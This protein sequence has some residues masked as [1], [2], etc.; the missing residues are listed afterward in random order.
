MSVFQHAANC[1]RQ[2]AADGICNCEIPRYL[3]ALWVG[4]VV[5]ILEYTVGIAVGSQALVADALH[6]GGDL[7]HD[8]WIVL[9]A[10]FATRVPHLAERGRRYGGYVQVVLFLVAAWLIVLHLGSERGLAGTAESGIAVLFFGV[11]ASLG[12]YLRFRILHPGGGI[13]RFLQ[14]TL[15]AFVRRKKELATYVGGVLHVI[16]DFFTS[17]VA[18]VNGALILATGNPRYDRIA[19]LV[20]LWS[21]VIFAIIT[22][23]FA[24]RHRHEHGSDC[25]HAH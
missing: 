16:T 19:A 9:V 15:R 2:F 22:F 21:L 20:I 5:G 13:F 4:L 8:L 14:K 7:V 25:G 17:I 10:L 12:A 24:Q 18:A 11:I 3:T 6:L 1:P 23:V